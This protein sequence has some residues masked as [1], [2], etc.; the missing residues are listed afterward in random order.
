M[1]QN[2]GATSARRLGAGACRR[3][4]RSRFKAGPSVYRNV[5]KAPVMDGLADRVCHDDDAAGAVV[6]PECF[7]G[8]TM[9]LEGAPERSCAIGR[10]D[11]FHTTQ[12]PAVNRAVWTTS[13]MAKNARTPQVVRGNREAME[14]MARKAGIAMKTKRAVD[15]GP[16]MDPRNHW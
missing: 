2:V 14:P 9:D 12:Y 10:F 8:E 7:G 3:G 4:G 16:R 1:F 6:L 15:T 5:R 13:A 11:R